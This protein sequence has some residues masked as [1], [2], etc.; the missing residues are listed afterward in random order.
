MKERNKFYNKQRGVKRRED[1]RGRH[2]TQNPYKKPEENLPNNACPLNQYYLNTRSGVV[3]NVC[4][5]SEH[6]T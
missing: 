3:G 5:K 2:Y 4:I 6:Y 1:Q